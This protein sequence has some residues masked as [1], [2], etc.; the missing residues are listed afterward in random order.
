MSSDDRPAEVGDWSSA[1][2]KDGAEPNPQRITLH[3]E[4]LVEVGQL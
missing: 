2:V 3:N 4:R 1:L